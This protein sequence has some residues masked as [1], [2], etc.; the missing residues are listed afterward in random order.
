MKALLL[1][2]HGALE[3]LELVN[4]KPIPVAGDRKS[5]V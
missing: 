5:V 4:D 3:N 1:K 2:E